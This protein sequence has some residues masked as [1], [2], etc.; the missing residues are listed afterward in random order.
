MENTE[1]TSKDDTT[2]ATPP[3]TEKSAESTPA[4]TRENARATVLILYTGG[5]IGMTP[6]DPANPASPLRPMQKED[7]QKVIPGLGRDYGIF[8]D[9]QGLEGQEPLDSSDV[10]ASHWIM[11]A[12]HIEKQYDKWDGFVILHGTDTMAYTTSGLSFIMRNLAKPVVVTGSQLPIFVERTDARLNLANAIHI[13][14]YKATGLPHV[15]EVVLCFGAVLLRGN[16]ARKM[17][18]TSLNGFDSPNFPPLGRL[19]EHIEINTSLLLPPADN[20]KAPFTVEVD[21]NTNVMD[22]A[23]FPGFKPGR[24]KA[25]LMGKAPDGDDEE[26]LRGIVMRTFGAGNAPSDPDLLR[27][28]SEAINNEDQ[29][30]RKDVL[31]VTQCA[32]G[33]VEMG[34]YEASSSLLEIGVLSGLDMT[35]EAALTKMFWITGYEQDPEEI[36]LQLQINQRGEQS[37]NLFDVRYGSQGTQDKPVEIVKAGAQ[38]PGIFQTE[39]LKRAVLRISGLGFTDIAEREKYEI[40]I[41][42]NLPNAGKSTPVDDPHLAA[43]FTENYD[44]K[45]TLIKDITPTIQRFVEDGRR[46]NI[47]VV[48]ITGGKI[49]FRG[50]FLSLFAKA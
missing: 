20:T 6:S 1:L 44:A 25:L 37:E 3:D 43:V 30:Q 46:I 39:H 45:K 13:A 38:P 41:F 27:V 7:L 40:R 24:L 23:L 28:L 29:E 18:S 34:L 47:T 16:R 32:S 22:I 48:P 49:W 17:S 21:L 50:M 11:M 12:K 14:G 26:P 4:L 15:S 9:I 31:N 19:G 8:W 42:V 5:T 2:I 33:M 35:P 36:K 10:N